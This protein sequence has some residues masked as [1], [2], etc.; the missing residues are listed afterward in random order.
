MNLFLLANQIA[1]QCFVAHACACIPNCSGGADLLAARY[2]NS[3]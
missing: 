3:F 1:T 2:Q